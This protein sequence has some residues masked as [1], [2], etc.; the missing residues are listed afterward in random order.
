MGFQTD[1]SPGRGDFPNVRAADR[2]FARIRNFGERATLDLPAHRALIEQ[3]NA[4]TEPA[5]A[6]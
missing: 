5:F 1:L 2:I 6:L 4:E 3:I